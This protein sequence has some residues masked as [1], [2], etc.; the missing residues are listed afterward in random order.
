MRIVHELQGDAQTTVSGRAYA[1]RVGHEDEWPGM[2]V[3]AL[4]VWSGNN[5][6]EE[7]LYIEGDLSKFR[8]MLESWLAQLA[9]IE[10]EER[11]QF[12]VGVIARREATAK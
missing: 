8:T 11:K 10:A 2:I 3:E 6:D 1:T 5:D 7:A 4:A 12:E 9:L